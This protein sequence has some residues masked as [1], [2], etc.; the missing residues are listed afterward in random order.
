MKSRAMVFTIGLAL[1]GAASLPAAEKSG[2][3][4]DG[5]RTEAALGKGDVNHARGVVKEI[6]AKKGM[7]TISHDAVPAIKWPAMTMTFKISTEL[8]RNIEVGQKVDFDFEV[9][10]MAG[11]ITR[12]APIR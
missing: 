8:A 2:M 4:M 7:V 12:I 10:G 11:T 6:D 9:K 1:L 3:D 5:M